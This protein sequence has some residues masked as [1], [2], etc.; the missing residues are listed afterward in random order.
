MTALLRLL[1][2]LKLQLAAH[3]RLMDGDLYVVIKAESMS[4]AIDRL[5]GI[6]EREGKHAMPERDNAKAN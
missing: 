3:T 1:L 6:V 4:K 2:A 5:I